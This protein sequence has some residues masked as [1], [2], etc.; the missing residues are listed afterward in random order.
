ML[1]TDK[2]SQLGGGLVAG[3]RVRTKEGF[4]PIE[5]IQIGDGVLAQ[6]DPTL[7][8]SEPFHMRDV[9]NNLCRLRSLNRHEKLQH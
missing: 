6:P 2:F 3:T 8:I 7:F 5:D 4:K 1:M 9:I